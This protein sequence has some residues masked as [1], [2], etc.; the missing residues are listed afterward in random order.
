MLQPHRPLVPPVAK[1]LRVIWR[2]NNWLAIHPSS[3]IFDLKLPLVC[4][5]LGITGSLFLGNFRLVGFFIVSL[6]GY[7]IIFQTRITADITAG[8]AVR[9]VIQIQVE[10][11]IAVK[12]AVIWIARITGVPV[13]DLT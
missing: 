9:K 8:Q 2:D 11:D 3:Q 10:A 12:L 13:P 5:I 7:A 4:K 6:A 1:K